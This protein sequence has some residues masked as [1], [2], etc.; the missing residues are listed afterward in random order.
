[1]I[2]DCVAGERAIKDNQTMYL[3]ALD[4]MDGS[5]YSSYIDRATFFNFSGRTVEA[6]TGSLMRRRP[7][8][9]NIPQRFVANLSK[10]SRDRKPFHLFSTQVARETIQMGRIGVLVDMPRTETTQPRPY[11]CSYTAENILDWDMDFVDDE[12]VFVRVVL[13]ETRR[14]RNVKQS[15][16]NAITIENQYLP[17]YR[18]LVLQDGQYI[19]RVYERADSATDFELNET[20][21]VD[22]IVPL[23][24]GKPLD[25]IP[26]L[27]VG[28]RESADNVE[29]PPIQD[30]ARLNISHYQSYAW[31][32]H[33]RFFTG[34][35]V[36]YVES[37]NGGDGSEAEF[38][39]GSSNVWVTP[40][41][42]KPGLLEMNGQG[43]KFLADA[44]DQKESQAA[45]LGGRMMGIRTQAVAESDNMLK[46]TE[47]NEQSVLLQIAMAMDAQM[48]RVLRWWVFLAG[49][50]GSDVEKITLE[51]NKDFLF[52]SPGAREFRA[53]HAMYTDGILPIDVLYSYF[54][55]ASI[56]PDWMSM[57][58][59]KKQLDRVENFP[60]NPDVAAKQEGFAD[61]DA[62]MEKE[63]ET[64]AEDVPPPPR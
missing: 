47:R 48:T 31:L 43:L 7:V 21:L 29:K 17:R 40:P 42:A 61:A 52:D 23:R 13:R 37:P 49:A 25:F 38:E 44:L 15:S 54:K 5:G 39:L 55:K 9:D 11:M 59:F 50:K 14:V 46:M 36:Y 51:F 28:P 34:F 2:R 45:S 27:I 62:K 10:V 16:G 41:G 53:I 1:M 18:E 24:Q 22:T 3:P 58:E 32:E 30:I 64:P 35:P 60:N 20:N 33:G 63:D 12:L 26:F 56:I 19:Q 4:S 57:E 8:I 6:M